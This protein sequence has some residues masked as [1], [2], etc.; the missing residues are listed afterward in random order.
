MPDDIQREF[1]QLPRLV[2][3]W[4]AGTLSSNDGEFAELTELLRNH[5]DVRSYFLQAMQIDAEL[6]WR[7]ASSR[8]VDSALVQSPEG[9]VRPIAS[10]VL[11][12]LAFRTDRGF[13]AVYNR[14]EGNDTL[15]QLWLRLYPT[16]R[17][18]TLLCV[19]SLSD[20]DTV[21][22]AICDSLSV[23][24]HTS[25][26]PTEFQRIA[27]ET[28]VKHFSSLLQR[29]NSKHRAALL[30]LVGQCLDCAPE[31][32]AVAIYASVEAIVPHQLSTNA[33]RLLC[34]R[35]LIEQTPAQM[36]R[37]LG[38]SEH[39]LYAQ[40]AETRNP[41]WK[42]CVAAANLPKVS[43][44]PKTLASLNWLLDVFPTYLESPQIAASSDAGMQP[45]DNLLSWLDDSTLNCKCFLTLA[46][47][48]ES[49]YRQLP[50]PK[51]LDE[52]LSRRDE[53]FHRVV[54]DMIAQ[55]E[56]VPAT[57][58]HPPSPVP[59]PALS[60][61]ALGWFGAIAAVLLISATLAL[62]GAT[63]PTPQ[64]PIAIDTTP[65]AVETSQ[66][67]P[68]PEPVLPPQ[69][70]VVGTIQSALDLPDGHP[71]GEVGT[72]IVAGQTIELAEGIVQVSTVSGSQWVLQAP[73]TLTMN[74]QGAVTLSHGRLVG[75]NSG[76]ALPLVV[77]T[78]SA[79]VVDVGT[80]FG[81]GVSDDLE[82]AVAV[83]EGAVTLSDASDNESSP[84]QDSL[85]ITANSQAV[86][87]RDGAIRVPPEPLLHDRDFIRPDEV[88][89]REE[90]QQ[91]SATAAERVAYYE[92]LRVDGL[93]AYQG[94]HAA[95]QGKEFSIGIAE[96]GMRIFGSVRFAA[97]L[98]GGDA[99]FSSSRSLLLSND[100]SVFLDLDVSPQSPLARS[101]MVDD[102]GMLGRQP[103]DIWLF[104]RSKSELGE[105]KQFSWVGLSTMHGDQRA[106]DEPLFVGKPST[107]EIFG[108]H[109]NGDDGVRQALDIDPNTPGVQS[110]PSDSNP[111]Q[112][113]VRFSC[114][115]GG[116]ATA[117][118]WCDVDPS[119]V[120]SIAPHAQ[121]QYDDLHFDRIRVEVS[122]P[123]DRGQCAF[124]QVILTSSSEAMVSA[125]SVAAAQ[126]PAPRQVGR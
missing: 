10:I 123:G 35:Y 9:T 108:T 41:I 113:I 46:I 43:L 54:T 98:D 36:A 76:Q 120:E 25:S 109:M 34:N 47:L 38:T 99:R 13:A 71:L 74:E 45:L 60:S 32:D 66:P 51:L 52:S 63:S 21:V 83:Y 19:P 8:K 64:Q 82:T 95:S 105:G 121:Q 5:R 104:W 37:A 107:L 59:Q 40:L 93:L 124:D 56:D 15:A 115:G 12:E 53:A 81:V 86:V 94:F 57:T 92:L 4:Q 42:A 72:S 103:G 117:S 2:D 31:L 126:S 70:I 112:W 7:M 49:L 119:Q 91:G 28:T 29:H 96:P 97:N 85:A 114:A 79:T 84:T 20:T 101:G 30:S 58:P 102:N 87:A 61:A 6:R 3:A 39:K 67:D 89:L 88:Q 116:K 44:P 68:I 27:S 90:V 122:K 1:P 50:L 33:L 16:I 48:H 22:D 18:C 111:H 55:L 14:V 100:Q 23:Q 11:N 125:L 78:P 75:L 80:E 77:H 69:P 26:S 73:L 110:M 106:T 65:K 24:S 118:V 17:A 62:W